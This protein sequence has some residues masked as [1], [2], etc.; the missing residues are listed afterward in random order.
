MLAFESRNPTAREWE[1][2]TRDV[3]RSVDDSEAGRIDI[4]T[5]FLGLDDDVV[6]YKIDYFFAATGELVVSHAELRFRSRPELTRSLHDG[7]LHRRARVRRL[8]A[9]ARRPDTRRS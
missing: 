6:R 1:R 8:G 7:R 3:V 5:V 9:T 4:K 2:W